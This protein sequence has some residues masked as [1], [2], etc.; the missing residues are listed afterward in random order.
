MSFISLKNS[1][2]ESKL[3]RRIIRLSKINSRFCLLISVLSIAFII[4]IY[5][6]SHV[7]YQQPKHLS[8]HEYMQNLFKDPNQK[9]LKAT[10]NVNPLS[11]DYEEF[12]VEEIDLI[13][14]RDIVEL[15]KEQLELADADDDAR[16]YNCHIGS[17]FILSALPGPDLECLND[18]LWQYFSIQALAAQTIQYDASGKKLS[19]KAFVTNRMKL[20]LN[21]LFDGWE[22]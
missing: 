18:I 1:K 13:W 15:F 19:L 12:D 9:Q 10:K 21:E 17:E 20:Q 3:I 5:Q 14:S 6:L 7:L 16:N 22:N 4:I 11:D 2:N 8:L